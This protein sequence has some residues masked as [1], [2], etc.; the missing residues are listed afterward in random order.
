MLV[1]QAAGHLERPDPALRLCEPGEDGGELGE[2]RT[3][4]CLLEQ[5]R[6]R[7]E[8]SHR[9]RQRGC[10]FVRQADTKPGNGR[11]TRQLERTT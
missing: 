2:R 6:Q 9:L 10:P 7:V 1:G 11:L 3:D 4:A 5:L 8:Q